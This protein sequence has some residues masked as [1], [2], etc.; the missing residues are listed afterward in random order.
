M[1]KYWRM[2]DRFEKDNWNSHTLPVEGKNNPTKYQPYM[3]LMVIK[4]LC[5]AL[6]VVLSAT[7]LRP[8]HLLAD[9]ENVISLD[10]PI[11]SIELDE[12]GDVLHVEFDDGTVI[13][14]SDAYIDI[15]DLE[16][17]EI[18]RMVELPIKIW[19]KGDTVS[20][21]GNFSHTRPLAVPEGET[22]SLGVLPDGK[23]YLDPDFGKQLR[24]SWPCEPEGGDCICPWNITSHILFDLDG[25]IRWTKFSPPK[26]TKY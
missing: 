23:V 21:L 24:C 25:T 8:A 4:F 1:R 11:R 13:D 6:A 2:L 26:S 12:N 22:I 14:G 5:I 10:T 9:Q 19:K 18:G 16:G 17:E 15:D 20:L 3:R 7:A